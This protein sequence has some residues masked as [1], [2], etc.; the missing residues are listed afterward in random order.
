M[1]A[2]LASGGGVRVELTCFSCGHGC[3]EVEVRSRGR[4][5]YRELRAAVGEI[6]MAN[7][8]TWGP[9]GEPRCPRCGGR[10][11]VEE[12]DRRSA[13]ARP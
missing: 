5:T 12:G 7:P 1:N 11:F 2:T 8:P 4:P 13:P 6:A 10:L 9:H 3:G